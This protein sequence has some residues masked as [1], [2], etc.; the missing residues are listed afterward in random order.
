MISLTAFKTSHRKQFASLTAD[1][2]LFQVRGGRL[3]F[4]AGALQFP[5]GGQSVPELFIP[6]H[7]G[8]TRLRRG[9]LYG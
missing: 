1:S 3:L 4:H 6:E 8:N 2:L 5:H 9:P 7:C